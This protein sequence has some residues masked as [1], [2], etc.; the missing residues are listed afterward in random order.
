MQQQKKNRRPEHKQHVAR[1][2]KFV[3]DRSFLAPATS[4]PETASITDA[5]ALQVFPFQPP[6]APPPTS[7]GG[8][9]CRAK[10]S[11]CSHRPNDE[12]FLCADRTSVFLWLGNDR[13]APEMFSGRQPEAASA[14]KRQLL[15]APGVV[16]FAGPY[17]IPSTVGASA[18]ALSSTHT[19]TVGPR[20]AILLPA[21]A[22]GA[23]GI[24]KSRIVKYASHGMRRPPLLISNKPFKD[25]GRS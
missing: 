1:P 15:A 21:Q 2:Q 18:M 11:Q 20:A 9:C 24:R 10:L 4:H 23:P 14:P 7:I 12:C 5:D 17:H 8:C 16:P 19:N 13:P 3:R 6:T 22:R 25:E